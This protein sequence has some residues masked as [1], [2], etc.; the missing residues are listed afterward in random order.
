LPIFLQIDSP[1]IAV[2]AQSPI[3]SA[4]NQVRSASPSPLAQQQLP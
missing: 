1:R 4:T 3:D 2:A